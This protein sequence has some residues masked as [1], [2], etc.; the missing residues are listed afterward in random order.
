M[1]KGEDGNWV[2]DMEALKELA[3]RFYSDLFRMD[4]SAGGDFIIGAFPSVEA[5]E[6]ESMKREVTVEEMKRDLSGMGSYKAPG[7]DGFQAIFIRRHGRLQ[8]GTT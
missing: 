2:D 6:W 5:G 1:L 4:S 8:G 7:P 3:V